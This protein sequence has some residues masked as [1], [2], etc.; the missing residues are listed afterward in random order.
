MLNYTEN[1]QVTERV[2]FRKEPDKYFEDM[3]YLRYC[4]EYHKERKMTCREK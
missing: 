1:F 4:G 3:A 2:H